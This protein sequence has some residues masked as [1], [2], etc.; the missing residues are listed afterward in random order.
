MINNQGWINLYKPK[1]ITSFQALKI[2]KKK[3]NFNK[4]GHAGTLDPI[5]EGILPIAIGKATKLIEY[6][7]HDFKKY[8][9]TIDWGAQTTTDDNTGE[10][11][12]KSNLIPSKKDIEDNITNFI[13]DLEQKPPK[14]SSVKINGTRAYKLVREKIDFKTKPK[15]V[16]VKELKLNSITSQTATF[17][18]ECGKGFYVRSLARDFAIKL[19]TFGH[20]S[21]LKRTKVGNFVTSSSILLDDLVKIGNTQELINCIIPSIFVLDDIL[22]YEIDNEEDINN[23]SLGRTINLDK[24]NS[25]YSF[26]KNRLIFLSNNGDIISIGK[27]VGNLFRPNKILI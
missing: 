27:L 22:A 24:F 8:I 23:L 6:I 21:A 14:V 16:F 17:E 12:K 4:L 3:F 2:I 7:N 15:R 10:I 13:G 26:K 19:G 1:N 20:I 9:F 5:A 18:I 11:I 25:K